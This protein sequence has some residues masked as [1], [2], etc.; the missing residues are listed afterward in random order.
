MAGTS[1][2]AAPSCLQHPAACCQPCAALTRSCSSPCSGL[3]VLLVSATPWGSRSAAQPELQACAM[4][5]LTVS[6]SLQ[7]G[8]SD[9]RNATSLGRKSRLPSLLLCLDEG[10]MGIES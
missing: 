7:R 1:A 3:G 5:L 6:S 10:S 2:A 9:C 8:L 4:L